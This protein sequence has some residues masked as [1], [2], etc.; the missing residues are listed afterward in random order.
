MKAKY[1]CILTDYVFVIAGTFFLALG[2]NNFLVPLKLSSGGISSLATIFYHLFDIPLSVTNLI[3]NAVL[4]AFGYKYLGK[5][6]VLKTISGILFLSFFLELTLKFPT[7]SEDVIIATAAGGVCVGIGVG[8]VISRGASTGG[9]DFAALIL[10]RFFPHISAT[11]FIMI[12]D[13]TIIVAAG[14]VFKSVTVTAYS[15]ISLYIS[16]K[17]SDYICTCGDSAKSIYILSE[18]SEKISSRIMKRFER[19]VTGIYSKGM[20]SENNK[21]MLMCVVSP[22]E[23]PALVHVVRDIDKSA[24]III[25]DVKEVLGE[26]FKVV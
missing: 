6:S 24:F 23:L 5:Q 8:L 26:G 4:F 9:S 22:K 16:I 18:K 25:S 11:D 12:I 10:N 14:A 1:K 7:Y 13:C 3:C 19:G 21:M 20:Y 15:V 2:L 17:I